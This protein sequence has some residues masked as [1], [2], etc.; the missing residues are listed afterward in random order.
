M[1]LDCVKLMHQADT[2]KETLRK[3]QE[4]LLKH[5]DCAVWQHWGI[6]EEGRG[7]GI[8]RVARSVEHGEFAVPHFCAAE[9]SGRRAS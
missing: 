9:L 4:G 5:Q 3:L 8:K 7:K 2:R 6:D 1:L